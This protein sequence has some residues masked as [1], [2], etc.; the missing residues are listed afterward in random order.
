MKTTFKMLWPIT[1]LAVAAGLQMAGALLFF[2]TTIDPILIIG[3]FLITFGIY[4]LN[5]FTDCEDSFNCP[6]Q[7]M[8]FQGQSKLIF[9]P[10]FMLSVSVI[11]LSA[12]GKLSFWHILLIASGI[13]YSLKLLPQLKNGSIHFN[14]LKDLLFIKN[15][16]VCLLWGITPFAVAASQTSS[17]MP[18]SG[19][20]A[21]VIL[22][23]CISTLINTTTCDVRDATGDRHVG[24]TTMATKF[25]EERTK[26][27]LF[28]LGLATSFFVGGACA[29]GMIGRP[30][31]IL[32]LA[33]MIWTAI[34]V[35][36]IYHT[37]LGIPR[38]VTEP[39][40][41]TQQIFCGAAL[42]MLGLL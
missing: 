8:F 5:R 39:L 38:M 23:F 15:L 41:E 1:L 32:Y 35:L 16:S 7:K 6:E 17:V 37:K 4:L 40:I 11:L 33:T 29:A 22:A 12:S 26:W 27:Y 13:L 3:Y 42:L 14:R 25:G 2:K 9:F 21:V 24:I 18:S 19:N 36:P 20:L 30:V 31:C 10:I 28:S 34:V